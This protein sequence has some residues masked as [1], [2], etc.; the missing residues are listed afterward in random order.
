MTIR[1]G[2]A[3]VTQGRQR[4]CD[5]ESVQTMFIPAGRTLEDVLAEIRVHGRLVDLA[6]ETTGEWVVVGCPCGEHDCFCQDGDLAPNYRWHHNDRLVCWYDPDLD[7][8]VFA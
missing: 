5:G 3:R 2:D 4:W 8:L 1:M 7:V 6:D